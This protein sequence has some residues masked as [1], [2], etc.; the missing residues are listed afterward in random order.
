MPTRCQRYDWTHYKEV[1][2]IAEAGDQARRDQLAETV[3]RTL[4]G[5]AHNHDA[6]AY[7]NGLL[8]T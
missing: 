5:R 6:R 1:L 4:Y 7:E 8:A 3:G 2:T